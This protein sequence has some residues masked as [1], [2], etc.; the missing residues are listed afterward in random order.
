MFQLIWPDL[1][2]IALGLYAV[3]SAIYGE[4][5]TFGRGGGHNVLFRLRTMPFRASIA[6]IGLVILAG[7]V[8]DLRRK[9]PH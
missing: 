9:F 4:L 5:R 1:L 8:L 7:V 6:V 2:A 3:N